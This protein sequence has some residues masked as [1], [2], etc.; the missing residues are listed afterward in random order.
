M[1]SVVPITTPDSE[2]GNQEVQRPQRQYARDDFEFGSLL[3]IGALAQVV[4]VRDIYS[5]EEY[6][7]KILDKKQI[8]RFGKVAQVINEKDILS[9]LDHPGVVKLYFT[10]QD[11]TWLYL[12]LEL[13]SNGELAELISRKGSL[14]L[15][16]VKFYA[17]E[18]VNVLTYLRSM[19]I[20]HRDIKPENLF[21]SE[22]GH[23][24]LG[25][26]DTAKLLITPNATSHSPSPPAAAAR[27]NT[28][29]GTAQ[30]VSPEMLH[31]SAVAGFGS[32]LWALGCVVF[33]MLVGSPPFKSNSEYVTFQKIL[34]TDY[35]FPDN[36]PEIGKKFVRSLL[37]LEPQDRLG[38]QHIDELHSHEFF[39][40]MDMQSLE[41]QDPPLDGVMRLKKR[42]IRM[43]SN[44]SDKDLL[45]SSD[46]EEINQS[47]QLLDEDLL[48]LFGT[49]HD[50]SGEGAQVTT[51]PLLIRSAT[52][53]P[54]STNH[55]LASSSNSGSVSQN[56]DARHDEDEHA[57]QEASP[58][59][60]LVASILKKCESTPALF[61]NTSLEGGGVEPSRAVRSLMI[62][63]QPSGIT[64]E[65]EEEDKSPDAG[66]AGGAGGPYWRGQPP[67]SQRR[68]KL[69]SKPSVIVES[70][71]S[72]STAS[73][74]MIQG[75]T[76]DDMAASAAS[77][78]E[79]NLGESSAAIL[80]SSPSMA[81][82]NLGPYLQRIVASD[83]RILMS[84]SVLKRRLFGRNRIL[85]ITDL[86]RLL[87]LEPSTFR[88]VCEIPLVSQL[89]TSSTTNLVVQPIPPPTSS[90]LDQQTSPSGVSPTGP[91]TSPPGHWACNFV[92][93]TEFTIE[94]DTGNWR[95]EALDGTAQ[96][97]V[98]LI[99]TLRLKA[100]RMASL[101]PPRRPL[102]KLPSHRELQTREILSKPDAGSYEAVGSL[103]AR[104]SSSDLPTHQEIEAEAEARVDA[105]IKA[106]QSRGITDPQEMV[107]VLEREIRGKQRT[108]RSPQG[109][110][111]SSDPD[112]D[113]RYRIEVE[114][115]FSATNRRNH[116]S[117]SSSCTIM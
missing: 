73:R 99:Q 105:A 46:E 7:L 96:A 40:T 53:A 43:S 19:G 42:R 28:F 14:P 47:T 90:L 74:M 101:R 26:F 79:T 68:P 98:T 56:E 37:T 48:T 77:P 65:A 60:P 9:K 27:M 108:P 11:S 91:P 63:R 36:V 95:G 66:G 80:A 39:E 81:M 2:S 18:L 112:P 29:V 78:R 15:P 57:A 30:Y 22:T 88:T 109:A 17:G 107:A 44:I 13:C 33:Q 62:N 67:G 21:I 35:K 6:A 51:E 83:E 106:I 23:L 93:P 4:H 70:F 64:E 100:V 10:F 49:T 76:N 114:D 41:H 71:M 50:L 25:D 16:L 117:S 61:I 45:N 20:A 32:D 103:Y 86:P 89:Q 87:V 69:S 75:G 82:Q 115:I 5:G 8:K 24:K 97:W 12:G 1:N 116:S 84:G 52:T 55:S 104:G 59:P 54:I 38:F 102:T 113:D 34:A 72:S 111:S 85:V 92:S 3:G 31:D 110:A 58:Q 94:T